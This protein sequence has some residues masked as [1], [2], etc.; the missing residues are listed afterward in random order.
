M[1]PLVIGDTKVPHSTNKTN[2]HI[3]LWLEENPA[4]M[5][6]FRD[7]GYLQPFFL[8]AL[9]AN[10]LRALGHLMNLSLL[11]QKEMGVS[12]AE[13]ERLCEAA[14]GAGAY[15]AKISGSGGGGIVIALGEQEMIAPIAAAI[16]AAGG[17]SFCVGTGAEGTRLEAPDIWQQWTEDKGAS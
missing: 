11:L 13:S 8:R 3:R 9:E 5:H 16:D 6:V 12:T 15:G 4:R 14:I 1:L 17:Q 7:M 2:T 10:D